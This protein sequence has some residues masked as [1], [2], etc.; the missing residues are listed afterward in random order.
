MAE[1]S[2]IGKLLI[3]LS[4]IQWFD[5]TISLIKPSSNVKIWSVLGYYQWETDFNTGA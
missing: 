4:S 1:L 5:T 3:L 2:Y